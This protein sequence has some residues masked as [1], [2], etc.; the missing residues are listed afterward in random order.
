MISIIMPVYNTGDFLEESIKSILQ[1]EY[2]DFE[3][4]CIDDNSSDIHTKNILYYY[5]Q[6]DKRIRVVFLSR[7]VGAGEAR[8]IGM[9]LAKGE[10][11]IF[12][13]SDDI[14]SNV[15]LKE[16]YDSITQFDADICICG[17]EKIS[18]KNGEKVGIY[19]P[20]Q[21][22]KVT[23]RSFRLD[24]L[25]EDGLMFWTGVPWNKLCRKTFL[26]KNNIFFQSLSSSND[27]FF[28]YLCNLT[29]D[30]IVYCRNEMPLISYREDITGQISSKRTPINLWYAIESLMIRRKDVMSEREYKKIMFALIEGS[31]SELKRCKRESDKKEFYDF[32]SDMFRKKIKH[33]RFDSKIVTEHLKNF[34]EKDFAS[35]WFDMSGDFLK[36]INNRKKELLGIMSGRQKILIWGMGKRGEAI[37][38]FCSLN[39]LEK[40]VLTDRKDNSIGKRS[41]YGYEI[42]AS[43]SALKDVDLL[44]ATNQIIYEEIKMLVCKRNIQ[45]LNLEQY[46]PIT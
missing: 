22:G 33:I 38:E 21:Y 6:L 11:V 1:Q 42:I 3:L 32:I 7:C 18:A 43:Y 19:M 35:G 25:P 4:L 12:L 29:A 37:Q 2:E 36:Q 5:K 20:K 45:I 30:K 26:E 27:I 39:G 9:K 24:E 14:F 28:S 46:C 34:C 15:L 31:L 8:N 41:P 13:D 23:K 44:I 10:Y 40:V 17:F 16:M